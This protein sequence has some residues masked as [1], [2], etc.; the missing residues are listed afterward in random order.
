M[1]EIENYKNNLD[2]FLTKVQDSFVEKVAFNI[3]SRPTFD[4]STLPFQFYYC[5]SIVFTTSKGNYKLR[6]AMTSFAV[7]TFWVE[8]IES[9]ESSDLTKS[10]QSKVMAVGCKNGYNGLP[11]RISMEF[12]DF[13]LIIFAA[14]IYDTAADNYEY[15]MNDEMLLVFDNKD[16]AEK[17]ETAANYA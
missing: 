14:E 5:F 11:Y 15:K 2:S 1:S 4:K 8:P 13:T 17:F 3:D 10:I 16:E 6:T 9:T 12:E 7:D